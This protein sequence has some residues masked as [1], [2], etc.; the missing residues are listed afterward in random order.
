V[1]GNLEYTSLFFIPPRAP[2]DLWDRQSRRGVKLYVR[3]VFIMDDA[4]QLMPP[5]LRFVRGIIDS[6]DLPLNISREILQHNKQ[7]D[8]IRSGSVKKVLHL[9][10]EI[11]TNDQEKYT[12][13]WQEFGR[14]LKEGIIEDPK[15]REELAKLLR[16]ASTHTDSETPSVSLDDYLARMQPGQ[17]KIYYIIGHSAATARNSPHLEIFRQKGVEVLLLSD[18]IDE[19]VVTHLTEYQGKPLQSVAKGELDLSKLETKPEQV[20]VEPAPEDSSDLLS[21]VKK[22]LGERVKDVRFTQRL[23]NSPAC[24]V[25][26]EGDLGSHLERLLQAAGQKVPRS[27]PILE[28]N[29]RHPIIQWMKQEQEEARVADWSHIL[30]DQ[31]LLSEG[32]QPEDPAGFVK[33]LNEM[34]LVLTRHATTS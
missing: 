31:A 27:H 17:E 24:L 4:E 26:N 33:R 13:F 2:F 18:D 16:F 23:T 34:F 20:P 10:E 6:S 28:L 8:S 5:Y 19:W 21:R 22:S 3:R 11:A 15:N 9:L 30:L 25:V 32:N 14:V 12:K 7:I 1:E 29:P